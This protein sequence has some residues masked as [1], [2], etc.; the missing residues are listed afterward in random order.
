[1]PFSF[2]KR[3]FF[4]NTIP[5]LY[6]WEKGSRAVPSVLKNTRTLLLF[7][8]VSFFPL[9]D[10]L[11]RSCVTFFQWKYFW[12]AW[13]LFFCHLIVIWGIARTFNFRSFKVFH[14][15]LKNIQSWK[16]ITKCPRIFWFALKK[17]PRPPLTN[18]SV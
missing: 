18:S 15:L 9:G 7:S 17:I 8:F 2:S 5:R 11:Q 4:I 13:C 16:R 1:M 10:I 3:V 6:S 12:P 14:D